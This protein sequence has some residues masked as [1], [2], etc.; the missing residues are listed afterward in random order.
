MCLN[1]SVWPCFFEDNL[2]KR[3]RYRQ[4]LTTYRTLRDS[5][6][7]WLSGMIESCLLVFSLTRIPHTVFLHSLSVCHIH[8][9]SLF[10]QPPRCPQA[11]I[12]HFP[13]EL[14]LVLCCPPF[15]SLLSLWLTHTYP[16]FVSIFPTALPVSYV[17][18]FALVLEAVLDLSLRALSRLLS[19]EMQV[20]ASR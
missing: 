16:P 10:P 6:E 9:R 17:C 11:L 13:A 12:F 2:R 4:S 7:Y 18:I 20:A 5:W 19:L 1:D 8:L 3:S 14:C 15:P